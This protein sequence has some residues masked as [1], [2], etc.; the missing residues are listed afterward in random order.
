MGAL[1]AAPAEELPARLAAAQR[2]VAAIG[3][4]G[5]G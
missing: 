5:R 2:L 3:E 1:R 4:G